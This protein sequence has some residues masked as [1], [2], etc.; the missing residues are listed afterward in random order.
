[1]NPLISV[2]VPIYNIEKYVGLCIESIINQTYKNLEIILVD[3]GATDRS[4]QLCDLYAQKDSRIV[5]IHKTNGGLVSARKTGLKESHGEYISYVDGDDWIGQGFISSLYLLL[6]NSNSDVVCAGYCRDLFNKS[7]PLLNA[8]STGIYNAESLDYVRSNMISYDDF[9]R[10]GITTYV[11][12]KLFKKEVLYDSQM[13]VD[14]RITIGEDAAV[15]YSVLLKAKKIYITDNCSYHYRQ[16]E[17]SM[18][19][20]H[21]SYEKDSMQLKI[22]NDYFKRELLTV[23][24]NRYNLKNQVIDFIL[25]TYI[26]RSGGI[27]PYS[28]KCID[29]FPFNKNIKS[30]KI[31][32]CGAGTFGQQLYKRISESGFCDIIGWIDYDYWEYRRCCINVDS[33]GEIVNYDYDYV[34]VAVVDSVASY[35][36]KMKLIDYGV[37]LEKILRVEITNEDRETKLNI[38]LNGVSNYE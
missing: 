11:W 7:I 37:S 20:T 33:I 19:K 14:E 30:K 24:S 10:H 27:F 8:I 9:F 36:M 12:N 34:L 38:F 16:R 22:L 26:I 29:T 28:G 18:L 21:A 1:M 17:D 6:E 31:V 23:D 5:V 32:I 2:I 35:D 15:T 13:N 3:D 25:S 4:G